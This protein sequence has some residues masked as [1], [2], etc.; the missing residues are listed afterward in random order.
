MSWPW[1]A[2]GASLDDNANGFSDSSTAEQSGAIKCGDSDALG[3]VSPDSSLLHLASATVFVSCNVP[4]SAQRL[5]LLLWCN[6]FAVMS[7]S[8]APSVPPVPASA[9]RVLELMTGGARAPPPAR[10]LSALRRAVS[11]VS[12]SVPRSMLGVR[13]FVSSGRGASARGEKSNLASSTV[14]CVNC[15]NASSGPTCCR[16]TASG[17]CACSAHH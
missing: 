1:A 13:D 17:I 3:F 12:S 5:V 8:I 4:D 9:A 6:T 16:A 14:C 10:K 11:R 7:Q 15:V 2:I